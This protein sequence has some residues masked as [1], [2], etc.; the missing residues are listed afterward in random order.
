MCYKGKKS[1]QGENMDLSRYFIGASY[2]VTEQ[3]W[4]T[5]TIAVCALCAVMFGLQAA[6]L[7]IIAKREGFQNKWMALVPFLSTYYIGVC[8]SKNRVFRKVDTRII[9]AVVAGL[10]FILAVGS[11]V[12]YIACVKLA[13]AGSLTLSID[14]VYVTINQEL[15]VFPAELNWAAWCFRYLNGY[16]LQWIN[17]VFLFLQILLL[18]A[19]FQTYAARRYFI[20][21]IFC[22]LFP[23]QGIIFFVVRNNKG[24]SYRDYIYA[25]QERQYS[26]Y[27]QYRQQ[28]FDQ[29]PYNQNPYSSNPQRPY[30]GG[31]GYGG[32]QT[33]PEDP[34]AEFGSGNGNDDSDPFEN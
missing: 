24:M 10:E 4:W 17:L 21:T 18:A 32:K 9:S 6:A 26:M 34:F 14:T 11:I 30:D 23:I 29:N 25:E 5:Y 33:P 22:V 15:G 28:N 2:F 8:A 31:E 1:F 16:I 3:Y 27:R 19:F 7:Y 20:F 12:Y 13:L